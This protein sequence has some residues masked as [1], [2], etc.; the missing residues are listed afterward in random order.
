MTDIQR[1]KKAVNWLI[2]QGVADNEKEV[3][4]LLGYTKSSFSQIMNG[5]VPLSEKFVKK[6]CK[7]DENI[8]EV[9]VLKGEGNMF[10]NNPNSLDTVE[11]SRE[12]WRIIQLQAESLA[13]RDKEI[14]ARDRQIDELVGL[15]KEQV[16]ESKKT[17]VPMGEAATSAV[18]G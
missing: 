5:R 2:F 6:L 7:L 12:A 11:L 18:A 4:D 15:L 3:A 16:R 13:L 14:A 10:K 1:V 17:A 9:W 8:N